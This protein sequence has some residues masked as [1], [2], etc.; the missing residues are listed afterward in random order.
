MS[1]G[2]HGAACGDAVITLT[3]LVGSGQ[4]R[5]YTSLSESVPHILG[6]D[7]FVMQRVYCTGAAY[8]STAVDKHARMTDP[9]V[10]ERHRSDSMLTWIDAAQTHIDHSKD[11]C[12]HRDALADGVMRSCWHQQHVESMLLLPVVVVQAV[13]LQVMCRKISVGQV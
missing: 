6:V 7:T 11:E 12:T 9:E 8:Q 13:T 3:Q 4:H 5:I 2:N 1:G 10:W